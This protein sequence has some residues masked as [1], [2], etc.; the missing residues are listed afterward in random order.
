LVAVDTQGDAVFGWTLHTGTDDVFQAQTRS[1]TGV[2]GPVLKI[3]AGGYNPTTDR[4][5][6]YNGDGQVA[7]DDDGDAVFTWSITRNGAGI[8]EH[9]VVEARTL[10]AAGVLGPIQEVSTTGFSS[11]T[12]R[13]AVDSD[14]DAVVTW[15]NLATRTN[16]LLRIQAAFGP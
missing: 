5:W 9:G 16:S 14:G 10:S 1:A 12:P 7:V 13:V 3:R 2:L 6:F 4:G 8:N 15:S 11:G